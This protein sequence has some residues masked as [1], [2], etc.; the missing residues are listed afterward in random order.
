MIILRSSPPSPFGRK[1]KIAAFLTGIKDKIEIVFADTND[2]AEALREQNP[3]GKIPALI[4]E[5]GTTLYD[6]RVILEYLDWRA[7]GDVLIPADAKIRFAVLTQAALADGLLDAALLQIYEER[8]RASEQRVAKWTDH[9]AG[10]VTRALAVFEAAPPAGRRDVA[11]IGLACALGYLDLRFGGR[12]RQAHKNLV[13][14]LAAF[15][16]EVP[17]FAATRA[18]A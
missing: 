5:D 14:W 16:A 12:W 13:M 8:F 15:E 7:G 18:G 3:L 6:S 1:I 10:K 11:H 17:A 4:L 2:P 9:Q